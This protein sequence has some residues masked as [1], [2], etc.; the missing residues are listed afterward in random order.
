MKHAAC[1]KVFSEVAS[2][3][4]TQRP[5][6]DELLA[7]L[8]QGDVLVIY[9][10][11]RLGRSLQHIV[12]LSNELIEREIGLIS[13]SAP[14]DTTAPQGRL[15]CNIFAALSEFERELIRERTQAGL[16]AAR[17]RGR[18]GGRPKGLLQAAI[19]TAMAAET[20]YREGQ[21]SVKGI[22]E[23]LNISKTTLY[24]YLKHRGVQIGAYQ[25]QKPKQKR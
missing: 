18:K 10:L 11:D 20:L 1:D 21:L 4:K 23:Q 2:G 13:L 6:L 12:T 24:A 14:I 22:C 8:R 19:A 15:V 17:A 25:R 5:V 7:H 16:S 9:K 3:A